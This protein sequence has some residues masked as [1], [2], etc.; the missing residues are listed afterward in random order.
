MKKTNLLLLFVGLFSLVILL[1]CSSSDD[2]DNVKSPLCNSWRLV[3]YGNESNEVLKEAEGYIYLIT[4]R[5]DGTYLAHVHGNNMKGEYKCEG[6][7]I[8]ISCEDITRGVV[9]ADPDHFFLDHLSDVY[10]YSVTDTE[11]RL[12]YAKDQYFKFR[13]RPQVT[14]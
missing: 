14:F 7:M 2:D 1:S 13:I 5:P 12:Y 3:S 10:T 6:N 8:K 4:F 11:L 9:G